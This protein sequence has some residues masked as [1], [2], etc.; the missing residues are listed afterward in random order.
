MR[1]L[2]LFLLALGA[3]LG[4]VGLGGAIAAV[5]QLPRGGNA[6]LLGAFLIILFVAAALLVVSVTILRRTRR[7]GEPPVL[8]DGKAGVYTPGAPVAGELDGVTYT[9]VYH[10]PVKG[11]N[12]RPSSLTISVPVPTT[13]EFQ[14]VPETWF[15]RFCKRLRVATEI[16]TGDEVFDAESYV[17]TD[18]VE[19]TQEYLADPVKRIAILDVRRL[20][21]PR[22]AL[23]DGDIVATWAG[24]DPG[25]HDKPDLVADAAARLVLLARNLPPH[26][27][28]FDNRVGQ[29]RKQWQAAL[30]V[31]LAVFALTLLSLI[32]YPPTWAGELVGTAAMVFVPGLAVFAYLSAWLLSGTSTSHYAWGAL[33]LGALFLF[34]AGSIGTVGLLNGTLDNSQSVTHNATI[35]DKYTTRSKN[36]THYHVKC[37]SWRP[38]GGTESFKVSS[39][40]YNAVVANRSKM[41]VTT[42]GGA[43]GIEWLEKRSVVP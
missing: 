18:A 43:L 38:G 21:F 15:D 34:P 2:A 1:G 25:K 28:E 14:V 9:S 37:S 27:P 4:I 3:V 33:M 40:D 31:F 26:K 23:D 11:K 20:G 41:V 36:T 30:W 13:G 42:R 39:A 29:H 22:V 16:Q 24:F 7:I 5:Q 17:R 32:A 6:G 12:G 19:F 35:V 8:V 10:P